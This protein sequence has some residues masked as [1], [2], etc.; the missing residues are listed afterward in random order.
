MSQQPPVDQPTMREN[1]V[2]GPA[3]PMCSFC[4]QEAVVCFAASITVPG[5]VYGCNEHRAKAEQRRNALMNITRSQ[6]P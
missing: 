3:W 2:L 1:N 4:M 6:Q 5:G